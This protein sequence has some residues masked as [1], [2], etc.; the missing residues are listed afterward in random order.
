M[1]RGYY[2]Q[3]EF[4]QTVFHV[5]GIH[6]RTGVGVGVA[7]ETQ[8]EQAGSQPPE[9]SHTHTPPLKT[10]LQVW[11]PGCPSGVIHDWEYVHSQLRGGMGVGQRYPQEESYCPPD[12]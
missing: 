9:E 3:I 11:I 12:G 8:A 4:V 7:E 10:P 5:P 2:W 1:D 6:S